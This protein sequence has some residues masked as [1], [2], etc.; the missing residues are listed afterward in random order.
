MGGYS[1][2]PNKSSKKR[3]AKWPKMTM[4]FADPRND[5]IGTSEDD[6]DNHHPPVQKEKGP[7]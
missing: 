3:K 7:A 1:M 6:Y 4:T 5:R 2:K